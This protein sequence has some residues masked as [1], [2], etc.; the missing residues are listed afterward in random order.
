MENMEISRI[1]NEI[2]DLLEIKGVPYK[3]IAYR[4][5][6]ETVKSHSEPVRELNIHELNKLPGIGKSIAKKIDD[7]N[8]TGELPYFE[9]LKSECPI[10]F[11]SLLAVEGVGPKTVKLLYQSLEIKNLDD[12]EEMA[13]H[14]QIR[15][16]KGMNEKKET[17]ILENIRF[18]RKKTR[19]LLGDVL[20][21]AN[22]IKEELLKFNHV[23]EVEVA[24]SIRRK[25]ETV[26]D[27]DILVITDN[28]HQVMEYFTNMEIIDRVIAKGPTRS[29][30]RLKADISCDLRVVPEKSFG[31]ALLYFTGS[32]E[33]NVELRK[34]SIKKGLKLNEY[35]LFKGKLMIAGR[36]EEE[37]FHKLG[38]NYLEPEL[39]QN[40]ED[41]EAAI[42]GNLPQLIGYHDVKGDLQMHTTWS[43]GTATLQEMVEAAQKL[44]HQ[45]IAITDH[46]GSLRIARG[47]DENRLKMQMK[48][49]EKL[50]QTEDITI[51]KGVEVNID[52]Y[53][54]LD[55]PDEVLMDL[56]IVIASIHSGFRESREQ[57]TSRIISAMEN[58]Y[59]NIIAHPTGRKIHQRRPYEL[60]LEKI[61]QTS[62][63]TGTFLEINSQ[64]DRLDLKDTHIKSA[65]KIG[66][67]FVINTDA[68]FS[69]RLNDLKL[70][71]ATARRG[72]AEKKDIINTYSLKEMNKLLG[73]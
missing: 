32:K 40:I 44:G 50:N 63:D 62:I 9:E 7:L 5:A 56:D 31:S 60:D 54:K 6:A 28:P 58:Q 66:C 57:L 16:I 22:E 42:K 41:V 53:G 33:I 59:V 24:G 3:P 39:R 46:S 38:M 61:F 30:V 21:L 64:A 19:S 29:T 10:D 26:G 71:I 2:A 72:W 15:R 49:I 4:R 18:A 17:N 65:L 36:T 43:D 52:S 27:I 13:K 47:M 73:N 69:E 51:L 67:K 20:P 12:L 37:I 35:G 48:E 25:Q 14:H 11:E 34:I 23:I 45:Y 55:M 68:H 8:K 70:G 1:L